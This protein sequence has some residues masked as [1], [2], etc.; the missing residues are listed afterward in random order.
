VIRARLWSWTALVAAIAGLNYYARFTSSSSQNGSEV[1]SWADFAGGLVVYAFWL[2]LVLAIAG[3]RRDL[4][5]LR[6]P[7]SWGRAFALCGSAIV[8]VYLFEIAVSVL[9]LPQSPSKE[10]GLTPTHWEPA[11]AAAFAANVALFTVVAPFVEELMFRG[12]GQSLLRFLGRWPSM[13]AVGLAFGLSHGLLE[14]LV[15]LVPFGV[16][17]AYVRDRTGSVVPGMLVHGLFN[18]VALAYSV[19]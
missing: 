16:A 1:Y 9:P 8:V 6:R 2:G 14:A 5:A 11:H 15:V 12:L 10:Q 3:G 13:L 4:L 18:G 19:L 17:L 7:R